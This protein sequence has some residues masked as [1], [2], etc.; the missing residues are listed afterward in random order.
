MLYIDCQSHVFPPAYAELLPR[1]RGWV[2]T[3]KKN[4]DYIVSYGDIQTFN[5]NLGA[6]DLDRKLKDMDEAG[7]DISLLS[8]NIPGP[9][10]LDDELQVEGARLCNDYMAGLCAGRPDR[11]TG[12]A[13]LPFHDGAATLAEFRRATGELGLRAVNLYSHIGGRPVDDPAFEPFYAEAER[14]GVP[15][16]IHPTVPAW[17]GVIKDYSMITMFGLMVD[18]SIAMLRLIMGGVLERH[19]GLKVVHPHC[20]GVLPYLMPRIVEQTEVKRRGREHI[21]K[22]PELYYKQV[23]LDIVS[24][25]SEAIR[26]AYDFAGPDR[27]LFGSDH[28]WVGIPMIKKYLEAMPL[29]QD[30]KAK[31]AGLNAAALFGIRA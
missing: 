7:I 25:S 28:P 31:I 5:L 26:F 10:M 29:P 2:R 15:L 24:P 12:I 1:N 30:E 4:G 14:T 20:G 21:R 11:L 6:Y 22:S 18:H 8:I 3:V 9:E 17:A 23:W 13:V 16:V 19:P 27:L